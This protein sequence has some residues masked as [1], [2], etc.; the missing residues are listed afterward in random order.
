MHVITKDALNELAKR[1]GLRFMRLVSEIQCL[2]NVL[3]ASMD[4]P[5]DLK[6]AATRSFSNLIAVS[7]IHY[8]FDYA[9][10]LRTVNVLD[11]IAAGEAAETKLQQGGY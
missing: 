5:P 9:E 11:E 10:I 7:C 1:H 2:R 8:G 6:D 4:T 3:F